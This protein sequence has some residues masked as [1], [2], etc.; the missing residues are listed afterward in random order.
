MS[1][2]HSDILKSD[3]FLHINEIFLFKFSY[4]QLNISEIKVY[5][6]TEVFLNWKVFAKFRKSEHTIIFFSR[7]PFNTS[8]ITITFLYSLCTQ[9]LHCIVGAY[10]NSCWFKLWSKVILTY[11]SIIFVSHSHGTRWLWCWL[12][13]WFNLHWLL[14]V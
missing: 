9:K 3:S 11:S 5:F 14:R 4:Q 6:K 1:H 13:L 8:I 10:K 7:L 2:I 12:A